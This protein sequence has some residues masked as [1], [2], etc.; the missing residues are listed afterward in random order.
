[1]YTRVSASDPPPIATRKRTGTNHTP[2]ASDA[3]TRTRSG[4]GSAAPTEALWLLPPAIAMAA[5]TGWN[6]I[7]TESV[8]VLGVLAE[9]HTESRRLGAWSTPAALIGTSVGLLVD[10]EM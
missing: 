7:R 10:Q 1:V 6:R 8:V 4:C 5:G 3:V 9:T 2:C